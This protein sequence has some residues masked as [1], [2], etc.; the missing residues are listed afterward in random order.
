MTDELTPTEVA[1]VT[2]KR[3]PAAQAAELAKRGIAFQFTGQG[4]RVLRA[5]AMAYDLL[6]A[7]Q[8]RGINLQA[9]R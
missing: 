9:V 4:V 8:R 2:G 1:E 7:S 5:V 3:R 6:P